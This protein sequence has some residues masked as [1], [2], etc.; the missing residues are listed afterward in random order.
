MIR[1]IRSDGRRNTT[2]YRSRSLSPLVLNRTWPVRF[3]AC[4]SAPP[5]QIRFRKNNNFRP[6]APL[7]IIRSM[8]GYTTCVG[9]LDPCRVVRRSCQLTKPRTSLVLKSII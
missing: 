2:L 3:Q 6:R 5:C 4:A 1:A 9:L 7:G 8:L